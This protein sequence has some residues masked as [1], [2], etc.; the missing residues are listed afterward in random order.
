MKIQNVC[1]VCWQL[2]WKI[3]YKQIG[4]WKGNCDICWKYTHCAAPRDFDYLPNLP[5]KHKKPEMQ[6]ISQDEFWGLVWWHELS[7]WMKYCSTKPDD[8]DRQKE[9]DNFKYLYSNWKLW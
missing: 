1:W 6:I 9:R 8:S 4:V 5:K 2:Y 3:W 7:A